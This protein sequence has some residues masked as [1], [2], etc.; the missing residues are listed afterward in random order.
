MTDLSRR[1]FLKQ[2][3]QAGAG[4]QVALLCPG[5]AKA[6]TAPKMSIAKYRTSPAETEGV[7][8]EATRL[9]RRAIQDLGGMSRFVSK[10]QVVW[11]KPNIAWDRTP[12]QAGNTNPDVVAT[13]IK[14]C[15]EAGAKEVFVGDN[16]CNAGERTYPNSR[17]QPLAEKAGARVVRLDRRKFKKTALN[18]KALKEWEIYTDMMEVDAFINI[19][20]AKHHRLAGATLGMK[21][22]M[23]VCGGSRNR[24]HQDLTN[25]LPDLAVFVKP[26]LTILD[27]IRVLPVNGPVGG[28]LEDV[29]RK[30]TIIAGVDQVAIDAFG[31][32]LLDME[33]KKIAHIVEAANRGLGTMNVVSLSPVESLV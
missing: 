7:A 31:A 17:I 6:S 1:D 12:E 18:G 2:A 13:V 16:P 19:P 25:V 33:P 23:G 32:A 30:D 24:F 22:L 5:L 21:N 3:A 15:Y 29:K 27:G 26:K 28:N 4:L 9:T 10:G 20:I 14:M 11:V 8:E